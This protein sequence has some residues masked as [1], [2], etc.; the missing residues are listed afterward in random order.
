MS[1]QAARRPSTPTVRAS[2]L[3]IGQVLAKL[4]P[5]FQDLSPSKSPTSECALPHHHMAA[6]AASPSSRGPAYELE[7]FERERRAGFRK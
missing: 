1:S 2:L 5:E 3:S 4:T 6:L 7:M